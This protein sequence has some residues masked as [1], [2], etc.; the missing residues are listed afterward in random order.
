MLVLRTFGQVFD[1]ELGRTAQS[2]PIAQ[3][4]TPFT[5][6]AVIRQNRSFYTTIYTFSML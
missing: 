1:G 5:A 4:I 6:A 2:K 3:F